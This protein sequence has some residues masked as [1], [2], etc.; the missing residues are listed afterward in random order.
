MSKT[1][2]CDGDPSPPIQGGDGGPLD[3]HNRFDI[4]KANGVE[5]KT[6]LLSLGTREEAED[7]IDANQLGRRNLS[8]DQASLLRGRRYNRVKKG[9]GGDRKSEESKPQNEDL[10]T[11]ETLAIQHGVSRATV[12]RDGA[13][14]SA[15]ESLKETVPFSLPGCCLPLD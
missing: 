12:E 9:H 15:V 3:G 8:P 1:W 7:W 2:V 5:F 14:A 4:C 11:A 13:F 6:V 10:K